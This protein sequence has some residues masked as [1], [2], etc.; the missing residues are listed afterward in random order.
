MLSRRSLLGILSAALVAPLAAA[1]ALAAWRPKAVVG[2][3]LAKGLDSTVTVTANP[4]CAFGNC[5]Y[6]VSDGP[7]YRIVRDAKTMGLTQ[8]YADVDEMLK[9][10]DVA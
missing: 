2:M 4:D 1:K 8:D 6:R 3:D 7:W 9:K 10:F 5:W